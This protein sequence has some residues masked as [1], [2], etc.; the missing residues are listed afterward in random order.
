VVANF[1]HLVQQKLLSEIVKNRP[2]N[3]QK[4]LY[5]DLIIANFL[6]MLETP[7]SHSLRQL[8]ALLSKPRRLKALPPDFHDFR[9]P[10]L[11]PRNPILCY[12]NFFFLIF[13]FE[14][15]AYATGIDVA[16]NTNLNFF[17]GSVLN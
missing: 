3:T 5:F 8:G 9:R 13:F 15:P 10:G 4:R 14:I 11:R 2:R 17:G 12:P 16:W 7:D 6:Q 1:H